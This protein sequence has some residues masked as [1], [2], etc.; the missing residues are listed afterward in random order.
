MID[1][2]DSLSYLFSWTQPL[3]SEPVDLQRHSRVP[4]NL[5]SGNFQMIR[6]HLLTG[7]RY[8]MGGVDLAS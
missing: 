8:P 2:A 5:W 6:V 4:A 1:I 3:E 7:F